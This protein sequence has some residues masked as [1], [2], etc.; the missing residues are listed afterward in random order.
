[1]AERIKTFEDLIAWQKARELT[2]RVY[3]TTSKQEFNRDFSLKDQMRR[4]AVSVM[5]NIAEGF[6]RGGRAEFHQFLVIAKGSCAELRSQLYIALDAGYIKAEGFT[7]LIL[8]NQEVARILAGLR[9]AVQRQRKPFT[10]SL[11]LSP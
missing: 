1:M 4:A 11:V 3:Q 9:K 5:S 2:R 10:K 7:Q 6:D 8:L